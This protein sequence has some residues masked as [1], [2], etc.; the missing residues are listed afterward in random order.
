MQSEAVRRRAVGC[1]VWLD[2]GVRIGRGCLR[3]RLKH[4]RLRT[5]RCVA[6]GRHEVEVICWRLERRIGQSREA[7]TDRCDICEVLSGAAMM[8]SPPAMVAEMDLFI[9]TW[10]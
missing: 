6:H 4:E 9:T 1:I 10:T 8:I 3:E 2:L 5:W 7:R